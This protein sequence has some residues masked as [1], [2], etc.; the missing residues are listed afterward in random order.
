M[1]RGTASDVI[2]QSGLH[3]MVA[4]GPGADRLAAAL[5]NAPGI[6]AAA[7]GTSLHVCGRDRIAL[8]MAI[9]PLRDESAVAWRE[10]DPTLEDIF[11]HLMGSAHDNV[12][13]PQAPGT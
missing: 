7:F 6:S 9:A 13:G 3:A 1:A 5:R 8:E 2:R 11:I 12:P 4:S 10:A